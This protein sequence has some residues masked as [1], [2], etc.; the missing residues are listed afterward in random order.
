MTTPAVLAVDGGNSKTDV[1]LVDDY[2]QPL[3]RV[4][5]PGSSPQSLG[6]PA[7]LG[8]IEELASTA[9][10][11]AGL[12]ED[13]PY[14]RHTSAYLAGLD[15]AEE[16]DAYLAKLRERNWSTSAAVGNDTFA[17]LR[18]GTPDG[19]G[20][21]VVCGAGVNCV[22]V[23]GNGRVHRFPALGRISGDWGG[24]K[25]LGMEALWSAVRAEDGRGPRTALQEAVRDHFQV[26]TMSDVVTELHFGR[27][28]M[29]VIH[30][31]APLLFTVA[32]AGDEVASTVVD[33]QLTEIALLATVSAQRLDLVDQPVRIVLG[34]GVLAG[35]D[36]K[37]IEDIAQRCRKRI[38]HAQV[39]RAEQP[40]V[41]GAA[42]LGL[43]ILNR[44]TLAFEDDCC[45]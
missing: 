35:I 1:W 14:A 40:P 10:R 16:E 17:L 37:H 15:L 26:A 20:I 11:R 43:D 33:R 2:G 39:Y 38:P 25:Q 32:E 34:G 8:V 19:V 29:S 3:A 30:Q 6:I 9:A 4:R 42:L 18:S 22:G 7:S 21:A 12:P 23:S 31:L 28:A 24:G 41:A 5:G 13:G 45:D 27:L 36:P 44:R